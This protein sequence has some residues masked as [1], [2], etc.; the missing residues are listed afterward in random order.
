MISSRGHLKLV[1]FGFAE[2][3]CD[4]KPLRRRGTPDYMAPELLI[5]LPYG[6]L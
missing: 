4:K 6:T 5:G 1:D 3:V 2:I